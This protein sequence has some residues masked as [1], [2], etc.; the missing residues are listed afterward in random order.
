MF[1]PIISIGQDHFA[2]KNKSNRLNAPDTKSTEIGILGGVSYYNG[3][4]NPASQFNPLFTHGAGGVVLRRNIS[5]RWALRF[6]GLWGKVKGNDL[7]NPSE[8]QKSRAV[9]FK[10]NIYEASTQI[11][12]NFFPYCASD[13]K[14]YF[15]PYAFVGLGVFA[16]NSTGSVSGDESQLLGRQVERRPYSK[17]SIAMPFGF[18]FKPKISHRFL[19][20]LEWGMRKTWTDYIDDVSTVYYSENPLGRKQRGNSKTKDWYSFAGVTLTMRIGQ[21]PTSCESFGN[22]K[23]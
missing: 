21:K 13:H 11:E 6:N 8:I 3:E 15:S 2:R 9:A 1:L 5:S 19:L 16:F 17:N 14:N 20:G 7:V 4:L 23:K 10:S 18:G 22:E 12:F